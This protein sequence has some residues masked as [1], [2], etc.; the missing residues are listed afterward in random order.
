MQ[1]Y[2]VEKFVL[3]FETEKMDE[4]LRDF[5]SISNL[6]E[7]KCLDLSRFALYVRSLLSGVN[8]AGTRLSSAESRGG[9]KGGR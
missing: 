5:Q 6:V 8:V 3:N 4:S 9:K 2:T 7:K 1:F